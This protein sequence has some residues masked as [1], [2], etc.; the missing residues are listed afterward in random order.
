MKVQL[1]RCSPVLVTSIYLSRPGILVCGEVLTEVNICRQP[2]TSQICP[3][4]IGYFN[5]LDGLER[6]R[7]E[8]LSRNVFIPSTL[9][10]WSKQGNSNA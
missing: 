1:L 3:R 10:V 5:W 2:A 6:S 8:T 7:A 9:A 4:P